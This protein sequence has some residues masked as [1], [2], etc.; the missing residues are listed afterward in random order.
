MIVKTE[1]MV[2]IRCNCKNEYEFTVRKSDMI[3]KPSMSVR[4]TGSFYGHCNRS[5]PLKLLAKCVPSKND[6]IVIS[7]QPIFKQSNQVLDFK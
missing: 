1:N 6:V 4:C 2:I 5:Y 3:E 7:E